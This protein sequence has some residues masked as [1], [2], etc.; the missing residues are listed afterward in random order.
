[1][2][3]KYQIIKTLEKKPERFTALIHYKNGIAILKK[4]TTT[5]LVHKNKF[6]NEINILKNINKTYVP[7][8]YE[9]KDDY[10]I[11]EYFESLDN[12]P[13][14]FAKYINDDLIE[15]IN[16]YL[17]DININKV[18]N[19]KKS[20]NKPLFNIYKIIIKQLKYGH[21]KFHYIKAL[22]LLTYLYIKSKKIFLHKASTKGD[23]TELNI[24]I[25]ENDIKFIDFDVYFSEGSF[26]ED[27][28]YL[29]LHQD[30]NVKDLTWQKDFFISHINKLKK[31]NIILT[32]E[33]IR[34]WLIHTSIKQFSIRHEQYSKKLI[35]KDAYI[36]KEEHIK[37]FLNDKKFNNFLSEIG[38]E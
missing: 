7:K 15:L 8:I 28:S 35:S 19:V 3:D 34:F 25:N 26:I 24:L 33:Y 38:F 29:L 20:Y 36:A 11:M 31:V 4:L 37:Y 22:F 14:K 2:I 17:L 32:K 21:I 13:N 5:N 1:M 27:A 18:D 30:V 12:S 10:I 9:N 16:T 6:L 23:M